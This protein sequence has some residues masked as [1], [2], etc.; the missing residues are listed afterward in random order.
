MW[1]A[2]LAIPW[3]PACFGAERYQQSIAIGPLRLSYSDLMRSV[4]KL[5]SLAETANRGTVA[6]LPVSET[7]ELSS[8]TFTLTFEKGFLWTISARLLRG[9]PQ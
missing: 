8:G 7:L 1:L 2:V 4:E 5:R 9:R 3:S 6:S